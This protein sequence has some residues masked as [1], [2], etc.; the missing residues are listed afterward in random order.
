MEKANHDLETAKLVFSH[1]P[2]FYYTICF[3]CQQSVE[4]YFI[5]I[6]ILLNIEFQKKHNLDYLLNLISQIENVFTEIYN[7]AVKLD[8]FAINIRYPDIVIMPTKNE[9]EEAI[10]IAE[11]CKKFTLDIIKNNL[12]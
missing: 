5:A 12:V 1:I 10:E 7:D 2:D 8:S 11:K 3:H 4:K 6:L 9:I